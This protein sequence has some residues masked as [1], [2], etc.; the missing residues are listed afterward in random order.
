[1]KSFATAL[2]AVVALVASTSVHA[3]APS[4]MGAA[5]RPSTSLTSHF[6][7][8][9]T[10]LYN[11]EQLLKAL[12]AMNIPSIKTSVDEKIQARGYKGD[13]LAADIVIPQANNY[14]VAFVHNGE[15]YELVADLQ[16][17]QQSMPV[18][19]FMEQVHQKYAF[20]TLVDVSAQDGFNLEKVTQSAD[21][22]ITLTMSRY[23]MN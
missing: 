1:M 12:K 16:F 9:S 8:I 15:T 19:A 17:W 23:N 7:T 21:G 13:T 5:C 11:K 10:K 22:A 6:S 14:D 4:R 3:F 18:D 20:H 2:V